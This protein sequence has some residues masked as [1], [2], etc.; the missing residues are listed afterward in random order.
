MRMRAHLGVT[1]MLAPH[2]LV[3]A[4]VDLPTTTK[5]TQ[6]TTTISQCQGNTPTNM[7]TPIT[8]T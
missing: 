6:T 2:H 3:A 7:T 8:T 4:A 1:L 5:T